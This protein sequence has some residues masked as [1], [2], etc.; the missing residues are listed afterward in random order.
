MDRAEMMKRSSFSNQVTNALAWMKEKIG[1]GD[2]MQTIKEF[3][4]DACEGQDPFVNNPWKSWMVE[5]IEEMEESYRGFIDDYDEFFDMFNEW[6]NKSSLTESELRRVIRKLILEGKEWSQSPYDWKIKTL[7]VEDLQYWADSLSIG[8]DH[9]LNPKTAGHKYEQS[10]FYC[11]ISSSFQNYEQLMIPMDARAHGI[12]IGGGKIAAN[13]VPLFLAV[14]DWVNPH[15]RGEFHAQ[16]YVDAGY[17]GGT[18]ALGDGDNLRDPSNR[19]AFNDLFNN[20]KK[21]AKGL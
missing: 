6:K 15:P 2:W 3:T 20:W 16:I 4:Y 17:A 10:D 9:P 5:D 14:S 19:A 8:D 7:T 21:Y 18:I 13:V 12:T 1:F 11:P